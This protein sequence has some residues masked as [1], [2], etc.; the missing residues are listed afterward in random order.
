MFLKYYELRPTNGWDLL[1]S[2]GHPA[3]FN[4]FCVLAALLHGTQTSSG[5]Q[6][7][8]AALNRGCHLY[9]AGRPSGW[10]LTHILVAVVIRFEWSASKMQILQ[11][12]CRC[13]AP[14][15]RCHGNHFFGFLY[16]GA[17]WRHL[18]NTTAP[19]V[20]G[21]DAALRQTTLTTCYYYL[22]RVSLLAVKQQS[23]VVYLLLK[24]CLC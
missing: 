5:R 6:P 13:P 15:G 24:M 10:A 14:K 17:H 18:A 12:P 1:A 23:V 16:M 19:S 3:N 4:G 8:F 20:C 21:G 22:S 7:N 11:T 9:S 2:L